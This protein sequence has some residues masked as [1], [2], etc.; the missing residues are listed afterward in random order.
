MEACGTFFVRQWGEVTNAR[1]KACCCAWRSLLT[2]FRCTPALRCRAG[3]TKGLRPLICFRW[4]LVLRAEFMTGV[5]Y[6]HE[7]VM[8]DPYNDAS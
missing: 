5:H 6:P 3:A 1:R 7:L 4:S 2:D 8:G